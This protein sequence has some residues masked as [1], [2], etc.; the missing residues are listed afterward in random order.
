V[1]ARVPSEVSDARESLVTDGAFERLLAGVTAVVDRQRRRAREALTTLGTE[2][3]QFVIAWSVGRHLH[4]VIYL[5]RNLFIYY[6]NCTK[7]QEK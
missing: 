5:L 1:Y 4:T 2:V 7:V 6:V 3:F